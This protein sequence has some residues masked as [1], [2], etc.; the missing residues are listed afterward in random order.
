MFE[1][2]LW[3]YRGDFEDGP[4]AKH[5]LDAELALADQLPVR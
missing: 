3:S 1:R 4:P 5:T 2:G